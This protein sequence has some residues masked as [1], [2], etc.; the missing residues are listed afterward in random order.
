MDKGAMPAIFRTH[1]SWYEST[2][3]AASGIH[4]AAPAAEFIHI[5]NT[6][7]HGFA[8]KMSARQAA[9]L[10]SAPGFIHMFPDSAKKLHT[11]YS[12]QFLHLEQSN[13]APSLLWKDS[14]YGSEAIVGIF[15]T[16]VWPQSQ[17][18]DDRKMSPVPSRWKGTCQAGPGF[19]P[20]LCNRK[21]IGARFFYRGYEAMSGPI[22]DTTEFKSPRDS[23]GHGTHTASTA[24]GRDVYRADLLGFAAG[25]ARGMAPKARIAAYKVCWQSGCFDSDILAAFDRA[26]SDGVDV[27]SLSVG[28]GVMPYYLD[29]IAIGSFAAMERGIFV[30]C[31]GGNEGP[32][33]MSVTNIA[34]WITTVGASTMDRS[35]PANVKLGNGM[36]IQGVS[37][38]SG[39]GLPHHQQLKLVFPKPNTKNDSYSAS[40]CMKNTLDP[41][42]AKGKIVFC[43]R[44]SNPR[45]EKGYNVLQA[46]GAGMILANAVA[47]GEG[48]VADSHLLPATAVGARSGSVIRKYMH[49]TRNPTATIE[50]L[51]TVYGSGNAPVIASF[52]SRGPNPETPEILKPDLVA[53]GVN[54]LASWTGDA[55]PTGLSADTRRVKFNILSGTS[56]AC[57][58]VSGLAALLKS[59][60]PTWSPAAIRSALMTTSTMEGKSGHV[61]GDEATSNSSTPFDFGSGLVDPVSALDPG[62]VYDLSVRDYE[63]FLCGLNYSSRARSTV[64]RSHFSCSKDSTTRDRPSSLNYPSFSVVFDLS[65]KAYTTTVSRTVTNVGPAKSLYT[66]RVVAPRGVEITVKPSKLEFQKRNQKMEFQMSITAKSSRSVAAGESETQFGVLIWS[67][68][69]GGR[70]MV[71]SPIAISRQ[72]PF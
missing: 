55:G 46:G 6:A 69:R 60:H 3:A 18:F 67:N 10:E 16:G 58:H 65:Q 68:T 66:A 41:K 54:I 39:K 38:Y 24:A 5:Y 44:G 72:Q 29:S 14:T 9:A 26:V 56:M 27:I 62:L 35:F 23:D 28:G 13:H 63:R 21:L 43:E 48:L 8:A 36:V 52:S 12:P 64:T 22:N 57:P 25:T 59:A 2:L 70:Q 32:T 19:D 45:V 40:L 49:S 47:D 17:S 37:L 33:D 53:P 30:A 15:D 4:A 42:A 61:I 7:M 20:K 31:S 34:P 50:F 51:G 71:Q 11:T 1:E